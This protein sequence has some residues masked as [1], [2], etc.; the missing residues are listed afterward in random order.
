MSTINQKKADDDRQLKMATST[1][2]G[3]ARL[4][5]LEQI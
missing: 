2:L 5:W 3:A 4:D 1:P